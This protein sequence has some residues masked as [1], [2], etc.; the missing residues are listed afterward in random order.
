MKTK[1]IL[2]FLILNIVINT[3]KGESKFAANIEKH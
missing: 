3:T 1:V 2:I